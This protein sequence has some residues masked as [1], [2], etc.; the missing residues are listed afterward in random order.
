MQRFHV[1]RHMEDLWS[2]MTN[3][4]AV[5]YFTTHEEADAA[6]LGLESLSGVCCRYH[7]EEDAHRR[8]PETCGLFGD[9]ASSPL[10]TWTR[11]R[12]CTCLALSWW[13]LHKGCHSSATQ[14]P[15]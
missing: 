13:G 12:S 3:G 1:V 7:G 2:V 11:P 10:A 9:A 4:Q 5:Y 8:A 6:A 15:A 14:A